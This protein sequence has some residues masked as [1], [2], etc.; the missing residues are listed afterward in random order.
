VR[1]GVTFARMKNFVLLLWWGLGTKRSRRWA[2]E[3]GAVWARRMRVCLGGVG[4]WRMGARL[5]IS[6]GGRRVGADPLV[7][8]ITPAPVAMIKNTDFV[9]IF[10]WF[11]FPGCT[12]IWGGAGVV[13][14]RITA[15]L[16][17]LEKRTRRCSCCDDGIAGERRWKLGETL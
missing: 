11:V 17:A 9:K 15:R 12:G 1:G 5:T 7:A 2:G 14:G 4:S 16:R 13:V 8:F 6:V 3:L 10:G